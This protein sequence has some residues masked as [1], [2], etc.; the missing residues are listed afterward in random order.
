MVQNSKLASFRAELNGKIATVT[1]AIIKKYGDS[2]FSVCILYRG[3]GICV[4]Y[5]LSEDGHHQVA[6]N[7]GRAQGFIDE[8]SACDFMKRQCGWNAPIEMKQWSPGIIKLARSTF[9]S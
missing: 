4:L 3:E 2:V 7:D 1:P 6:G 5:L 8:Q 9:T